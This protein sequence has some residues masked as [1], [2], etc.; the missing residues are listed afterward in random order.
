MSI[1]ARIQGRMG[2]P[3]HAA[4]RLLVQIVQRALRFMRNRLLEPRPV[5]PE[6]A[7]FPQRKPGLCISDNFDV[8]IHWRFLCSLANPP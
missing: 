3:G 6:L 1:F 2:R 7:G 8:W 5:L 4:R